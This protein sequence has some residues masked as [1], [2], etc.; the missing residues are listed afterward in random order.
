MASCTYEFRGQSYSSEESAHRAIAESNIPAEPIFSASPIDNYERQEYNRSK[1]YDSIASLPFMDEKQSLLTYAF[2]LTDE[3]SQKFGQDMGVSIPNVPRKYLKAAGIM[4]N[5][6][7]NPKI[8]FTTSDGTLTPDR[9]D[10][11]RNSPVYIVG[12]NAT[13]NTQDHVLTLEETGEPKMFYRSGK[14]N[15]FNTLMDA[16][17]DSEDGSIT[18]GAVSPINKGLSIEGN[19]LIGV[20]PKSFIPIS[21]INA[22]S[23]TNSVNGFINDAII[24]GAL[25]DHLEFDGTSY[26]YVGYGITPSERIANANLVLLKAQMSIG[27]NYVSLDKDG[28]LTFNNLNPSEVKFTMEDG[29]EGAFDMNTL[30]QWLEQGV[31][32]DKLKGVANKEALM[33]LVYRMNNEIF[34]SEEN[35]PV[36]NDT[37]APRAEPELRLL[38]LDTLN[39]L[40][41]KVT[42][43]SDYIKNYGERFG[44]DPSVTALADL[45]NRIVALAEGKFTNEDIAEELAH[46]VIEAYDDQNVI[47]ELYEEVE[48]TDEWIMHSAGY[49]STYGQKFSGEVLEDMVHKEVLGK[50]L[51]RKVV[52]MFVRTQ[53]ETQSTGFFATLR[54][55]WNNFVNKLQSRFTPQTKLKMDAILDEIAESIIQ[56]RVAERYQEEQLGY[57]DAVMFSKSNSRIMTAIDKSIDIMDVRLKTLKYQ[58]SPLATAIQRTR[59]KAG[60]EAEFLKTAIPKVVSEVEYDR[61]EMSALM[62]FVDFTDRVISPLHA[63]WGSGAKIEKLDM[64]YEDNSLIES[65]KRDYIPLLEEIMVM[66]KDADVR[67]VTPEEKAN[68]I[69][70]IK[71]LLDKASPLAANMQKVAD[72]QA[73]RFQKQVDKDLGLGEEDSKKMA[74]LIAGEKNDI[75]LLQEK[76]GFLEHSN[77]RFLRMLGLIINKNAYEARN[78]LQKLSRDF[79]QMVSEGNWTASA[80][81]KLRKVN[82]DGTASRFLRSMYDLPRFYE[83]KIVNQFEAY[84]EATDEKLTLEEYKRALNHPNNSYRDKENKVK[85]LTA[86]ESLPEAKLDAYNKRLDDWRIE[87]TELYFTKEFYKQRED[88]FDS[89]QVKVGEDKT[90]HITKDTREFL[91][92]LSQRRNSIIDKYKIEDEDGNRFYAFNNM[93]A[94]DKADLAQIKIERRRAKEDFDPVSLEVKS[95]IE[96]HIAKDLQAIDEAYRIASEEGTKPKTPI[97]NEF[98]K[99]LENYGAQLKAAG[100]PRAEVNRKLWEAI[101]LNGGISFRSSYWESLYS[102]SSP[103]TDRLNELVTSGEITD[104]DTIN[105]IRDLGGKYQRRGMI[106]KRYHDPTNPSE[107]LFDAMPSQEIETLRELEDDIHDLLLEL[108]GVLSDKIGKEETASLQWKSETSVNE[109]YYEALTNSGK[110]EENFLRDH[111]SRA[112]AAT[113]SRVADNIKKI[114]AGQTDRI[115]RS[116][117]MFIMSKYGIEE[118]E[119]LRFIKNF[120]DGD[121]LIRE[122]GRTKV[123]PYFKRNAPQGYT[124]FLENM[125]NEPDSKTG[126]TVVES[127]IATNKAMEN[128][129]YTP[130]TNLDIKEVIQITPDYSWIEESDKANKNPNYVKNFEGGMLQPSIKY[131]DNQFINDFGIDMTEYAKSGKIVASR[132]HQEFKMWESL[133]DM[134]RKGIQHYK[135]EGRLNVYELPGISMS[136]IERTAKSLTQFANVT[137]NSLRDFAQNTVD[138]MARGEVAAESVNGLEEVRVI[139]KMFT[140]RLEDDSDYSD[141]FART[142]MMFLQGAITHNQRSKTI[143]DALSLQQQ[144][145]N[146]R[147]VGGKNGRDS[148]SYKMFKEF[149]DSY[150]FGIK[151][152]RKLEYQIGNMNIDFAKMFQFFDEKI[153]RF[154]NIAASPAIALTSF[155]TGELSLR[156]EGWVGE[157]LHAKSINWADR[158]F[159]KLAPEYINESGKISRNNKMYLMAEKM[160]LVDPL[161]KV[162]NSG[163]G[164]VFRVA[165]Q[166]MYLGLKL[167]DIPLM[168]R[169]ML[170][171]LDDF[172]MIK[173]QVTENGT[174]VDKYKVVSFNEFR[175]LPQSIGKSNKELNTEWATYQKDSVYNMLEVTDKEVLVKQEYKDLLGAD[176]MEAKLRQ[177]QNKVITLKGNVD[178]VVTQDDRMAASRDYILNFATAHRGWFFINTQRALK[179]EQFN[180]RTMQFEKGWLRTYKDF[181]WNTFGSMRKDDLNLIRHAARNWNNLSLA[182]KKNMYR[183]GIHTA[184]W[185]AAGILGGFLASYI[186]GDDD[187]EKSLATQYAAYIWFRTIN[188]IG[189]VHP[190]WGATGAI[191]V[192]KT[193]FIAVN[194][195]S[196]LNFSNLS[197]RQV[198]SGAY[199]GHSKL[200]QTIVK[201]TVLRHYY[202]VIGIEKKSKYYRLI[203]DGTLLWAGINPKEKKE[204]KKDKNRVE[205]AY[206]PY[207][208]AQPTVFEWKD[209]VY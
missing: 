176:Y 108:T 154:A 71:S 10:A 100:L 29:T 182:D 123:L 17:R 79:L 122:F 198:Q 178:A 114:Q 194:S 142:Y 73:E 43:I 158:E 208:E 129:D 44:G 183:A 186:D 152:A 65:I 81:N 95:G 167:G 45:T 121:T 168:G 20:A 164:R 96:L 86:I 37:P 157:H 89:I 180:Y 131:R 118:T 14:G 84:K 113:F 23:S 69:S 63:I 76:F 1:T 190:I 98:W 107:V 27:A 162:E 16:L 155:T 195:L 189:S 102:G 58:N 55:I 184:V 35:V 13:I 133:L 61:R 148:N 3:F 54:Q 33:Y 174:P 21:T 90:R 11:V 137:A 144:V 39:S 77:N 151:R 179:A 119:V 126:L 166:P 150:F 134:K 145:A 105:S 5:T 143:G 41:I 70:V 72:A 201:Q 135:D 83:D 47:K 170:A 93:S 49:Y 28:Y 6:V 112:N 156:I 8:M 204:S 117:S 161:N 50:I 46:F 132:N 68:Y 4:L 188:E 12:D 26:R 18:V 48:T 192:L 52:D 94:N 128:P 120:L 172:R 197:L 163:Y 74:E 203:N 146:Q 169:V 109:A 85:K 99:Y 207:K 181:I 80:F 115:S 205:R 171:T 199:E 206:Q 82:P 103:F 19:Q 25:A 111:M 187:D 140:R 191:D 30:S 34:T 32:P 2:T 88:F 42:S 40:G 153:V 53:G 193:P 60:A 57:K 147:F 64:S 127:L 139:P 136:T 200:Y 75:S 141:E 9:E 149:V 24:D 110:S 196:Q 56:Q 78:E 7:S 209:Y 138:D 38:L 66:V 36:N 173:Y 185:Y 67:F 202:D 125:A 116:L 15:I 106:I 130:G 175:G 92:S 62:T 124:Q 159:M 177:I 51:A 22:N 97:K 31:L 165:K 160:G 87:N 104:V 101:H 59:V 91:K